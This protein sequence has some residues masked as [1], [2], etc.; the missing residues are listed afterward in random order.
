MVRPRRQVTA[1]PIHLQDYMGQH[2]YLLWLSLAPLLWA[3][4]VLVPKRVFVVWGM[5][6]AVGA[7]VAGA[8]PS[9]WWLQL[10]VAVV[11][12]ALLQWQ[13]RPRLLDGQH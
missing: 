1:M 12:G 5:A 4:E 8:A 7:V 6:A 2:P 9:L 13:L 3:A 10:S 11:A